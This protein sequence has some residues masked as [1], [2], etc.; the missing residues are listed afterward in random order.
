MD[1]GMACGKYG[2]SNLDY[3]F[4]KWQPHDCELPRFDAISLL[5][6]LRNKRVVF[7]ADSLN[8]NQWVSLVCLIES[9]IHDESL[10]YVKFN[11][12]L[13][14]F[15]A[16]VRLFSCCFSSFPFNGILQ[17]LNII[18]L[19]SYPIDELVAKLVILDTSEGSQQNGGGSKEGWQQNDGGSKE[20]FQTKYGCVE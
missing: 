7:V 8:R 5:E 17:F 6:K 4:W 14:T 15:E 10:K 13:V 16:I 1:D 12:S 18:H 9:S 11:G 3:M 19:A 2:R 20:Q